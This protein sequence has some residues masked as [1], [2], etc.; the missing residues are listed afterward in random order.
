[1]Q[2]GSVSITYTFGTGAC[3]DVTIKNVGIDEAPAAGTITGGGT[4]CPGSNVTLTLAGYV[5]DV[6]K[7]STSPNG[8]TWSAIQSGASNTFALANISGTQHVQTT[9]T[10]GV[11]P[12]VNSPTVMV[13]AADN[14][15]P[16]ALC[17]TAT[18]QLYNGT[19][20]LLP[21]HVDAGSTDNCGI[22]SIAAG[23]TAF[24]CT[25]LGT[26][27]VVLTITDNSGNSSTCTAVVTVLD[28]ISP[29]AN[30]QPVTVGL[31]LSGNADV[32]A[33]QVNNGSTDNCSVT[34][35]TLTTYQY[36]AV[37]TYTD[38]LIVTDDSGNVDSCFAVITVVDNN[39]P[40]ATCNDT[41][42]YLDG[43][44]NATIT[45]QDLD[46]GSTD[47]GVITTW[48]ASQLAF[49]CSDLGANSDTLFVTDD[50]GNTSFCEAIVTV[51]DTIAPNA[52]CQA[53]TVQLDAS[54]N[55][56]LSAAQVN[57]GS[58]DNCT[59]ATLSLDVTSFTC[60]NI[61]SANTVTLTVT[62]Q[63]GN[64]STCTATITV[65]DND[66]PYLSCPFDKVVNT[67][68]GLCSAV[69]TW[70]TP[71]THDNCDVPTLVQTGGLPNGSA[72]PR[73]V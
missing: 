10:R 52:I 69:V 9:V 33:A 2:N 68:L 45:A 27:N 16:T 54:G 58:T 73:C 66:P 59:V 37:G 51:L 6:I 67:D 21:A 46:G 13:I 55:G 39:P 71:T 5:G 38:T 26:N 63:S 22:A 65:E 29:V 50:G 56:T 15:L 34:G 44:G 70:S 28:T 7:W 4:F 8:S 61:G 18:I 72:F 47:N 11:C 31:D 12:T 25:N 43:S 53:V 35:M 49:D 60:A 20:N 14:T 62:D 48:A 40:T 36:H 32:T 23:Q 1:M 30:C 3:G 41:I 64:S 19:A 42:I 24:S 57:N 17:Q